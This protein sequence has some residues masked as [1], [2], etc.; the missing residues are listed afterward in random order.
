MSDKAKDALDELAAGNIRG[1]KD[2]IA[3]MS[4]AELAE[5]HVVANTLESLTNE[6]I[7]DRVH[8]GKV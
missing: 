3:R 8:G 1:A 2:L 4:N 6:A 7:K 5:A